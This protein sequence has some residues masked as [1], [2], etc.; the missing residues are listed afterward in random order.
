MDTN[1][2]S[3]LCEHKEL[4]RK[5]D[6]C[7]LEAEL[8]EIGQEITELREDANR[9]RAMVASCVA[10]PAKWADGGPATL[11]NCEMWIPGISTENVDEALLWLVENGGSVGTSKETSL[12]DAARKLLEDK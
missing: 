7:R 4:R 11:I 10:S 1:P 8:L 3:V 5:C 2:I 12:I 6:I 9:Y